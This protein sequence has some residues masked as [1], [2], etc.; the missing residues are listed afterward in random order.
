MASVSRASSGQQNKNRLRFN[1]V[2]IYLQ[3]FPGKIGTDEERSVT[4]QP[5]YEVKVDGIATQWGQLNADGSVEL[6]IPGGTKATL[7]VL[8]TTYDIEVLFEIEAKDTLKG[9]Q[10]R[11]NLLGYYEYAVDDKYGARTDASALDFQADNGLDPDGK[12]LE[13]TTYNKLKDVFGE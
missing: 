12:L 2:K 3:R 9:C 5:S 6:C 8:G 11:L 1:R 7:E 4:E 13:A 10:R